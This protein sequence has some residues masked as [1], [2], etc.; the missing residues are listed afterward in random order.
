L[1]KPWLNGTGPRYI[2]I[3]HGV[4]Y[5]MPAVREPKRR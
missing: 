3:G 5:A 4:R 1:A 2:K